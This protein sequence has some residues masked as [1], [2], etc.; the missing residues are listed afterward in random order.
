MYNSCRDNLISL[1][2]FY[3][4]RVTLHF[5]KVFLCFT[6]HNHSVI[7][8]DFR[9]QDVFS[10]YKFCPRYWSKGQLEL[11]GFLESQFLVFQISWHSTLNFSHF[12]SYDFFEWKISSIFSKTNYS[13]VWIKSRILFESIKTLMPIIA[14][15]LQ[16]SLE[17]LE[18]CLW[19]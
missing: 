18:I 9:H 17:G 1:F 3:F 5:V 7:L 15:I 4:V 19:R 12:R 10:Y 16:I 8:H 6:S 2:F 14:A 13:N 11:S